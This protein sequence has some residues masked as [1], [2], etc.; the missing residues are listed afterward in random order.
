MRI[1]LFHDRD[2]DSECGIRL[3]IDGQPVAF[4]EY[5]IDPGAGHE[6]RDYAQSLA[7]DVASAS[8]P[9]AEILA[10]E[11]VSALCSKYVEDTPED[12][13]V[14]QRYFGLCVVLARQKIKRQAECP[15]P[16]EARNSRG[17]RYWSV[18]N[19]CDATIRPEAEQ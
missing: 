6:F 2:P 10:S 12:L 9:V 18:C 8:E 3:F 13:R 11:A 14:V 7:Y 17:A 16:A 1:E 19:L 15:H 4:D 5:S